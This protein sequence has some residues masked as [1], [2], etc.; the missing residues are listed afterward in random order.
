MTTSQGPPAAGH[1]P[2]YGRTVA[3][4]DGMPG[5]KW[6]ASFVI[7]DGVSADT[8]H[9]RPVP[10]VTGQLFR[11]RAATGLAQLAGSPEPVVLSAERGRLEVYGVPEG[12][13]VEAFNSGL[14]RT[15]VIEAQESG[16]V[17]WVP[18]ATAACVGGDSRLRTLARLIADHIFSQDADA[19]IADGLGMAM[20]ACAS[21]PQ[22]PA[23]GARS[24]EPVDRRIAR[25]LDYIDAHYSEPIS[26]AS[27]AEAANLSAGHFARLFKAVVGERVWSYVIRHR[28]EQARE[29]LLTTSLPIAE[30]TY[31][32]GFAHQGHLTSRFRQF[33]GTTPGA[34]RRDG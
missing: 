19:L 12:V 33:Y 17:A 9:C 31:R 20:M 8:P 27:I 24:R 4:D 3:D 11:M 5:T 28:C 30:V 7:A 26:T 16:P 1:M 10:M 34:L 25:A 22:R 21:A 32:C 29:L 15:V 2:G 23:T 13:T 18:P 14:C 6:R